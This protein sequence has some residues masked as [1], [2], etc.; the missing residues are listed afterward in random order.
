MIRVAKCIGVSGDEDGE[1]GDLVGSVGKLR[2]DSKSTESVVN[3]FSGGGSVNFTRKR[4]VERDGV[5]KVF[6]K[7]G[8]V[9][10]FRLV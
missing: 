1:F 3:W 2:L 7:L 9:F 6:T 4:V 8:R 10:K 5:V